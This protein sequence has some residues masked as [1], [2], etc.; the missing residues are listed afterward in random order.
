MAVDQRQTQIQCCNFEQ[1]MHFCGAKLF[2]IRNER[3]ANSHNFEL[4]RFHTFECSV[5]S[6]KF[7]GALRENWFI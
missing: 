2:R 4:S 5:Q 3:R 1:S 7:I 6:F